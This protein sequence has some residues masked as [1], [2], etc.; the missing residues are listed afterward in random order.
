MD[1][2]V[3]DATMLGAT[4]IGRSRE[5]VSVPE[6]AWRSG[7]AAALAVACDRVEQAMRPR[8]GAVIEPFRR[9]T[10][11]STSRPRRV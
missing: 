7:A 5:H 9:S 8:G 4:E 10:V 3:R 6:R 1:A 11:R 2:A